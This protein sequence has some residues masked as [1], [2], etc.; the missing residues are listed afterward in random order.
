M[1]Y[2]SSSFAQLIV[3]MWRWALAPETHGGRVRGGFPGAATFSSRISDT[4]LERLILPALRLL[5]DGSA[6]LRP[7][8]RGRV[9]D[10]LIYI[11]LTLF[12]LLLLI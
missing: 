10:Y 6:R 7:L 8:Q 9:Q 11:G 3:G 2:T 4:V 1:Q 5:A 12:I